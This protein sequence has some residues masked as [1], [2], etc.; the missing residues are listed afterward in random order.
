MN[1]LVKQVRLVWGQVSY[2]VLDMNS[3]SGVSDKLTSHQLTTSYGR[4]VVLLNKL[5]VLY[6]WVTY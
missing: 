5:V 1:I 3:V 4:V 2:P 6:Q